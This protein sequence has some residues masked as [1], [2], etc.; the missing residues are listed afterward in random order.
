MFDYEEYLRVEK[1]PHIW[2]AGCGDGI[3]LKALIRAIDGLGWSKDETV[4][5]SGIGCSSR[6]TGYVDFQTVHTL[7][8]RALPFATGIKLARPDQRVVV[9]TG[10]GDATAIGGNHFIHAARRNIDVTVVLLNNSIYG[11]TGG[12]VSPTTPLGATATT[13]PF[14]QIDSGFDISR[15]AIAS[16]AT[17]VARTTA[18]HARKMEQLISDALVNPG[19]SLVEVQVACPTVYGKLNKMGTPSDMLRWFQEQAVDVKRAAKLSPEEL[20][21]KIVTGLLHQESRPEYAESYQQLIR[22]VGGEIRFPVAR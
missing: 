7:H 21:G 8:G 16:G 1:F 2:C 15:L 10:D 18:F 5:V 13:A 6:V 3:L 17:F 22:Q 20:E 14:G 19:F 9:L 12:Q 11:M 4:M